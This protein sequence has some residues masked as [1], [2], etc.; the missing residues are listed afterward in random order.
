MLPAEEKRMSRNARTETLDGRSLARTGS[1][2]APARQIRRPTV[3]SVR[4]AAGLLG[5]S[6]DALE[7]H[8]ADFHGYRVGRRILFPRW[9]IDRLVGTPPAD[10]PP[11]GGAGLGSPV[12][13]VLKLVPLLSAGDRVRV[14]QAA[15]T[16]ASPAEADGAR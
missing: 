6:V 1:S 11:V 16:P 10:D 2:N 8:F 9:A 12:E 14:A 13:R 3:Y 4:E 7:R 5:C 15:L